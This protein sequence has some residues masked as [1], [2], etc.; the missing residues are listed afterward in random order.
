MGRGQKNDDHSLPGTDGTKERCDNGTPL[1]I[2]RGS[3]T[4]EAA[5]VIPLLAICLTTIL[6]MFRV[7]QVQEEIQQGLFC[8]GRQAAVEGSAGKS[9]L[10]PLA[11]AE[12][13]FKKEIKDAEP[14]KMYVENGCGGVS[15][16]GSRVDG[17]YLVLRASCRIKFPF[18]VLGLGD[19]RMLVGSKNRLWNGYTIGQEKDPYVYCTPSGSV[20]H[21]SLGCPSLDLSIREVEYIQVKKLRNRDGHKYYPCSACAGKKGEGG[22]VYITDYGTMYHTSLSCSK[23]KRTVKKIRLSMVGGRRPCKRCGGHEN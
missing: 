4:V 22:A 17:D 10:I 19:I 11:I 20:Y 8:A 18:S 2:W 14:I 1:T 23:L 9:R 21:R 15:L 6:F 7:T 16:L 13:R 5:V 3:Y 12:L